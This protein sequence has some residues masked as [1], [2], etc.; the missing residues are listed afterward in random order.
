MKSEIMTG[1]HGKHAPSNDESET[2]LRFPL[3]LVG[4]G[5]GREGGWDGEAS[6]SFGN[7]VSAKLGGTVNYNLKHVN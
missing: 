6:M 1:P 7:L 3:L 2:S 5:L 4:D